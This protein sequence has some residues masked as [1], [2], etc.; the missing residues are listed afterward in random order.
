MLKPICQYFAHVS[1][2]IF[3]Q[4][5]LLSYIENSNQISITF[6][7]SMWKFIGEKCHVEFLNP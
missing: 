1:K 5:F 2:E 4:Q 6:E 3:T 7:N